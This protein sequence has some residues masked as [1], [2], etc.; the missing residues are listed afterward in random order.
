[1]VETLKDT[2]DYKFMKEKAKLLEL[3]EREVYILASIVE[4]ETLQDDEKPRMAGVYYNRLRQDWKLEA[5][6]TV[7]FAIGDF[8]LRRILNRHLEFDSPFNTYKYQG[9]PPGPISM[10]SI[11]SIDAVLNL[12]KHNYMFFCSKGDG[13]G[14]HSFAR[15]LAQHNRNAA[16][17]R[18]NMR[19]SGAWN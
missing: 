12:E 8:G 18:E 1:M 10:A 3:S 19:R 9:L 17:Y 4:R 16:I 6:P 5:D 7:K 14:Y 13:T 11:A 15:T 2:K